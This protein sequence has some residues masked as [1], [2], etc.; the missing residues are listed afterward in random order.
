M[1]EVGI[2]KWIITFTLVFSTLME[3]LDVTVVN[4]AMP[5]MMGNLGASFDDIGWVITAYSVAIIMVLPISGWLGQRFGRKNYYIAS[6]VM[7]TIA[8]FFCGHAQTMDELIFFRFI[9]GLAG[10]GMSPT[11]QAILIETWPAEDLG[12][13]MAMF[14]MGAVLGPL[15]GPVLGGYITDHFSWRWCFYINIP[16]SILAIFFIT[17]FIKVTPR[18]RGKPIDWWGLLLLAISV[19]SMQIVLERG[20][21]EDW[22]SSHYILALTIVAV[23]GWGLFIWRELST[24]H[25]VVNLKILRHRSFSLGIFTTLLFG[26]GMFGSVF[27]YPLMFQN[28]LG[29]TAEQTGIVTIPSAIVTIMMMPLVGMLM[30][31]KM[32]AQILGSMGIII[33]IIFCMMMEH[34]T[35]AYGMGSFFWP[36]AIRGLGM[37]M[38]FVPITTLAVQDLRGAEIGQGTGMN[39]MMRQL[40]GSFGIALI[41][42]FVD[43]RVAYHRNILANNVNLYNNSLVDRIRG[44]AHT[45]MG[46]GNSPAEAQHMAYD[47]VQ[48]AVMKQSLLMSYADVFWIVGIFFLVLIPLLLFQKFKP[49]TAGGGMMA[50]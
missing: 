17:T 21:K 19:A 2:K 4:V 25:P 22:F 5:H 11:A 20:E 28:L 39:T 26:L 1:A 32:P 46:Q 6:I 37:S 13:A 30:K 8:S 41:T 44:M 40:G 36:L 49:Q 34:T 45:F 10:G 3:L 43:R 50:H 12:M 42:T 24:E 23:F 27:V 15:I 9:Q 14:G 33:F 7:F 18:E 35:L 31:K 47:A 48:G 38:L 16:M 29:F